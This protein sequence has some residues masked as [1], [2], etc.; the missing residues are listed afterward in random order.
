MEDICKIHFVETVYEN[1]M[2]NE[3]DK[4]QNSGRVYGDESCFMNKIIC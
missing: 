1:V 4:L 2:R 3:H